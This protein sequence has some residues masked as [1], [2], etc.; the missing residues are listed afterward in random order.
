MP[1]L[2]AQTIFTRV[3]KHL[4]KQGRKSELADGDTCAYRSPEGLKCALGCLI[5]SR[6][7]DPKMERIAIGPF[8]KAHK[9]SK[10][11]KFFNGILKK[12]GLNTNSSRIVDLLMSLQGVHDQNFVNGWENGLRE[13]ADTFGLVYKKAKKKKKKNKSS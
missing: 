12:S 4:R 7:Y 10:R 6:F 1:Y 13:V 11:D 5:P 8:V 9:N 2:S 3:V